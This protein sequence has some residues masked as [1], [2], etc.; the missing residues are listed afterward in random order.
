[1]PVTPLRVLVKMFPQEVTIEE[2][3]SIEEPSLKRKAVDRL[4]TCEVC[5]VDQAK[6]TCPECEIHSCGLKCIAKHKN[7]T[8]CEGVR[9]RTSF[10]PLKKFNDLHFLNDYRLLEEVGRKVEAFSRDKSKR[11]TRFDQTLPVHLHRLRK[12]IFH[13]GT[14][15]H[16][17][18]E[19][20][21]R[22]RTNTTYLNWRT[23]QIDWKVQITFLNAEMQTFFEDR[24]PE[25]MVLQ[26]LISKYVSS[27][28]SL[29]VY[30]IAGFDS[31][32]VLI[33]AEKYFGGSRFHKL[34]LGE[35]LKEN[36]Y[37]KTVVEYPQLY[38]VIQNLYNYKTDSEKKLEVKEAKSSH[39]SDFLQLKEKY[40][41]LDALAQP[42]IETK[43]ESSG[44]DDDSD[45]EASSEDLRSYKDLIKTS[46]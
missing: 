5:Q 29:K 19:H 18:P 15:F 31:I 8:D 22:R 34:N 45:V 46:E 14:R 17:L 33:K 2:D 36:L 1:M 10:V 32:D 16:F 30:Q 3:G 24:C 23:K 27:L 26:D 40:P 20:F 13:R 41:K 9:S 37:G 25:S 43:N 39:S 7:D 12:A 28:K 42:I 4:G 35:S 44:N 11:Y 21:S 6:Y 38:V